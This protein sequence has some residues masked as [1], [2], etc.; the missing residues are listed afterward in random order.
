[1]AASNIAYRREISLPVFFGREE[2][3]MVYL[4]VA[5]AATASGVAAAMAHGMTSY[6]EGSSIYGVCNDKY[7]VL[8]PVITAARVSYV[9]TVQL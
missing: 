7:V 1:M 8:S 3:Y 2:I 9:C 4:M 6:G 5:A